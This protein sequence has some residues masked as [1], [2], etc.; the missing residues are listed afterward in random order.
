MGL[1]KKVEL[2]LAIAIAL[3]AAII[4]GAIAYYYGKSVA[5]SKFCLYPTK[6][7]IALLNLFGQVVVVPPNKEVKGDWGKA[8]YKP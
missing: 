1:N 4:S 3:I 6:R 8:Y 2:E 7:S 5:T